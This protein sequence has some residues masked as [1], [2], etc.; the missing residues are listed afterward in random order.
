MAEVRGR[1]TRKLYNH[2]VPLVVLGGAR[3]AR[4]EGSSADLGQRLLAHLQRGLQVARKAQPEG[5]KQRGGSEDRQL[6]F[7]ETKSVAERHRAEVGA[8]QAEGCGVRW[9]ARCL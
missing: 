5:Q 4:Q 2:A 8:W 1:E 6:P 7:A 3:K 9:A